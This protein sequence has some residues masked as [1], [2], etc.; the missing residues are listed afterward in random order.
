MENHDKIHEGEIQPLDSKPAGELES[1]KQEILLQ[2]ESGKSKPA[3]PWGSV[4]VTAILGLLTLLSIT[5]TV[6]SAAIL[7]KANSGSFGA[8]GS[9]GASGDSAQSLPD[10]VG[11]C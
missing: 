1:L 3:L 2:A 9:G 11:G 6:Q 8:G 4:A 7:K 5:Q 10:M